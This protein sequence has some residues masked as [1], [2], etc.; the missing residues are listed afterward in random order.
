[1]GNLFFFAA[2]Y[3][4]MKGEKISL[5]AIVFTAL[6]IASHLYSVPVLV[7]TLLLFHAFSGRLTRERIRLYVL[8]FAI[9]F[10]VSLCPVWL[11]LGW[12]EFADQMTKQ[13]GGL[14]GFLYL[15]GVQTNPLD[16]LLRRVWGEV[17]TPLILTLGI[18]IASIPALIKDSKRSL[19][20]ALLSSVVFFT[21][22]GFFEI[23]GE[24]KRWVF[25]L[26]YPLATLAAI[27]VQQSRRQKYLALLVLC[28]ILLD[29]ITFGSQLLHVQHG[30]YE[31]R[32]TWEQ[33]F[34]P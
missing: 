2:L 21:A 4:L 20:F 6:L 25:Y 28:I 17:L 11:F 14:M 7:T 27:S 29:G 24:L 19:Q 15:A 34:D 8:T 13:Q 12:R 10:L 23:F 30:Q 31:G 26:V 22:L 33:V 1:L 32:Y 9:A 5:R 16:Y 18:T 3:F